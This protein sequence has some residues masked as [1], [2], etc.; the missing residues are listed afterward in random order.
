MVKEAL[1]KT[2]SS[3]LR[4]A[5]DL[6]IGVEIENIIYD[7]NFNRLPANTGPVFST[8]DLIASI[9]QIN[10][11]N[12]KNPSLTI[13]PGGQIECGSQPYAQLKWLDN[14]VKQY[15]KNLLIVAE[16][17]NLILSDFA[18]EPIQHSN[19]IK[20]IKEKKYELMHKYFCETGTL[21]HEMMLNSASIQINL[22]YTSL[23]LASKMAFVADCLH[24]ITALIFSNAPFFRGIPSGPNNIREIVW[25]NTDPDRSNCLFDHNISN[26]KSM[27]DDYS[28]YVLKTPTIF[29]CE[30]DGA[31]RTFPGNIEQWLSL[32][33]SHRKI[34]TSDVM[35]A[36]RQIFTQVRFKHILEIRGA[37]RLPFGYEIVPAAFFKGLLRSTKILDDIFSIC[38]NWS[39]SKR[40]ILNTA[41]S[42]LNFNQSIFDGIKIRDLCEKILLLAIDGL[43]TFDESQF[44]EPFAEHFL[45]E[46]PF[47]LSTQKLYRKSGKEVKQ[48]LKNRWLDQ[49]QFLSDYTSNS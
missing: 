46:G 20:I 48:F 2:F 13:E 41:A 7:K 49:K 12:D 27:I 29:I 33:A 45:N 17:Q 24:P 44:L 19:E 22:D 10:S 39:I 38:K 11:Y 26:I 47:S 34:K 37:D 18:I 42:S 31:V 15:I 40:N 23:E 14:E 3:K 30:Q 36:L 32:I 8:P 1:F 43:T 21:G 16:E 9:D 4:R 5:N 35:I 6:S 25:R 28:D